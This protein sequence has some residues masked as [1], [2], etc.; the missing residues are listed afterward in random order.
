LFQ[1]ATEFFTKVPTSP[2]NGDRKVGRM[3]WESGGGIVEDMGDE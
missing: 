2:Q 1:S 3:D